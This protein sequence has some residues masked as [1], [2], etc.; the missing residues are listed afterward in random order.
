MFSVETLLALAE[1]ASSLEILFR[2]SKSKV[3]LEWFS[4]FT[5]K[6]YSP[7]FGHATN[8]RA[9]NCFILRIEVFRFQL[10]YSNQKKR[11]V[12]TDEIVKGS[13]EDL[14]THLR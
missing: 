9:C 10:L 5:R 12:V 11:C 3:S 13:E 14:R 8:V 7:V 2:G 1:A 6:L 4:F